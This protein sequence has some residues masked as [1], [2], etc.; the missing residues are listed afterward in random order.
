MY[1]FVGTSFPQEAQA[2]HLILN[3]QTLLIKSCVA[4]TLKYSKRIVRFYLKIKLN[5]NIILY[6]LSKLS[7]YCYRGIC[8]FYILLHSKTGN[9]V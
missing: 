1:I 2:F 7:Y 3:K 6:F 5:I 4:F 8:V 9:V